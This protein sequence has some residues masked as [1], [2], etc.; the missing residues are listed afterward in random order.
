LPHCWSS[1][2]G[3]SIRWESPGSLTSEQTFARVAVLAG[4]HCHGSRG[5]GD[6]SKGSSSP[7]GYGSQ[8][9]P[10]GARFERVARAPQGNLL[11]SPGGETR[12]LGPKPEDGGTVHIGPSIRSGGWGSLCFPS[13]SSPRARLPASAIS[14]RRPS[15]S[16]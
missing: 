5:S 8:E 16:S 3:R 1:T 10:T 13:R 9:G 6:A 14:L 12:L 15:S 4:M 2:S 11:R 7:A